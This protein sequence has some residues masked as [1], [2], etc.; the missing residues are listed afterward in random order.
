MPVAST[1]IDVV[2]QVRTVVPAVLLM[3]SVG[4]V[5]SS[6]IVTLA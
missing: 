5:T 2:A 6:V 1:A 3:L 4:A